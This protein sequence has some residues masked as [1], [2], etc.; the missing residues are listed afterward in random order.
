VLPRR[1]RPRWRRG[2]SFALVLGAAASFKSKTVA[3][4]RGDAAHWRKRAEA[5]RAFAELMKDSAGRA[6]IVQIAAEYEMLAK[7]AEVLGIAIRARRHRRA[8]AL[9]ARLVAISGLIAIWRGHRRSLLVV[10][11]I[12]RAAPLLRQ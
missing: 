7:R 12:Y 4:L 10:P 5:T 8:A 1:Q 11:P 3:S 6:R 9:N 2:F